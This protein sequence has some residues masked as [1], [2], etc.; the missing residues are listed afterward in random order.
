MLSVNEAVSLLLANVD[1]LDQQATDLVHATGRVLAENVTAPRESPPFDNSAMD[2][3]A[4]RVAD[5]AG[6]QAGK[7][8]TLPLGGE[9]IAGDAASHTLEPGATLRINTGAPLPAGAEAVVR[10]EDVQL[11]TDRVSFE[12]PAKLNQNI[13]RAGENFRTGD[14]LLSAGLMLG[15][16]QV[17]VLASLGLATVPV[18]RR[19]RVALIASGDE[20][21]EPGNPLGPGQIYDSTRFA[22]RPLLESFGAEVHDHGRVG[23]T[24]E[25]THKALSGALDA[26]FDAIITTGGVSMG[27]H[28]F[29]RPTLEELGVDQ[30]L[31]KVRQRPGKPLYLGRRGPT[32]CFGLP[33]NPVSVFVTALVYV[34]A[35]LLKMQGC[36]NVDLPWR[37][38]IADEPFKS[39]QGFTVFSR[40]D[41]I[42]ASAG[43]T[44]KAQ[45]GAIRIR[46]SAGQGSHQFSSLAT[47]AGLVRIPEEQG[48]ID[49]GKTIDFLD[50]RLIF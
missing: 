13:R 19:P 28:D 47:S 12:A 9:I 22:L 37:P 16:P 43:G 24:P 45:D 27:S 42:E 40:A 38:A 25:A 2:G 10:I 44:A 7:P 36:T 49:A 23:D 30:I 15:P 39:T 1:V 32:I 17:G 21:V 33:G 48:V 5:L 34:R 29:I 18:R 6:A 41:F 50:F 4:V 3:F 31:W 8:I 46:P 14:R 26:G 35:A 11:E 20:L